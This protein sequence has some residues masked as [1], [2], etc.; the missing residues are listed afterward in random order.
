M[1]QKV[2]SSAVS[3]L[4]YVEGKNNDNIFAAEVGHANNQPWCNTFI[5]AVFKE[6]GEEKAVINTAAVLTT[7]AWAVKNNRL[8]TKQLAKRGDLI[9]MNFNGK[10]TPE[11]IELAVHDFD[12]Q[13]A[14]VECIGGNT[15]PAV[16]SGSQ[17]NGDGVY[18]KMRPVAS[19]VAV[20]RPI[21]KETE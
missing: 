1:I 21:Y 18:K 7:L 15:S 14:S 8:I 4:G 19:I 6:A 3:H 11:H 16:N 5:C 13:S 10:K 12:P 2:I 20:V 9:L 17:A